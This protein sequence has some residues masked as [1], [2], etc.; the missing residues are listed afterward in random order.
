MKKEKELKYY[1]DFPKDQ[2][3]YV[4]DLIYKP[5]PYEL[6]EMKLESNKSI[7]GWWENPCWGGWRYKGENIIGWRRKQTIKQN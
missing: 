4:V 6:V 7:F 2:N 1:S 3:G 5:P